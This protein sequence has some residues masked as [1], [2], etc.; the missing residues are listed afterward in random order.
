MTTKRGCRMLAHS[1]RESLPDGG[2]GGTLAFVASPKR[3]KLNPRGS[4]EGLSKKRAA[5]PTSARARAKSAAQDPWGEWFWE[6]S[7]WDGS[8]SHRREESLKEILKRAAENLKVLAEF[9]SDVKNIAVYLEA[10]SLLIESGRE[11]TN[12]EFS[13][14]DGPRR[15]INSYLRRRP[16]DD[17][18]SKHW[19]LSESE[20][21]SEM[22]SHARSFAMSVN[23]F[24]LSRLRKGIDAIRKAKNGDFLEGDWRRTAQ[25]DT[26]SALRLVCW[27]QK[28]L[29]STIGGH[30]P[31][32]S[33][34]HT[35]LAKLIQ[36]RKFELRM[37]KALPKDLG[38]SN[39][40]TLLAKELLS[41][42]TGI[43][44]RLPDGSLNPEIDRWSQKFDEVPLRTDR[45]RVSSA[46]VTF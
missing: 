26:G 28:R 4:R 15:W 10:L 8:V 32:T 11:Q 39:K 45:K 20:V 43:S 1:E 17:P 22:V 12:R 6:Y 33:H 37:E 5:K 16:S 21:A 41:A 9:D 24:G 13:N 2:D 44:I 46:K 23:A 34:A 18:F 36:D 7:F 25:P 42:V 19:K 38:G 31:E 27:W 3:G 40:Q 29:T 14:S 35:R 30:F